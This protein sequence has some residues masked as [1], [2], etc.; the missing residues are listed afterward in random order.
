M[1][2]KGMGVTDSVN[3]TH[4]QISSEIISGLVDFIIIY[5]DTGIT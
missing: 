5:I 3:V 4:L 1:K 2:D